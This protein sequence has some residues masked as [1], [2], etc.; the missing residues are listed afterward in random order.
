MRWKIEEEGVGEAPPR[1]AT[2]TRHEQL[3]WLGTGLGLLAG[4]MP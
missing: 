4:R 2:C 3:F 1:S